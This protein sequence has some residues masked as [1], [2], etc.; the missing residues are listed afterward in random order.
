MGDVCEGVGDLFGC[1][2]Q[3]IPCMPLGDLVDLVGFLLLKSDIV[4]ES[5]EGW[6]FSGA[7][8]EQRVEGE[9]WCCGSEFLSFFK[10][11]LV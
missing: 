7:V 1:N 8:G 11:S 9:G 3:T 5:L 6:F 2:H 4:D 10:R